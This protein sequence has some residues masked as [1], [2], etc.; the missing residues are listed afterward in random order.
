MAVGTSQLLTM[1]HLPLPVIRSFLPRRLFF[2]NN[3][4]FSPFWAAVPAAIIPA[5][6][7]PTIMTSN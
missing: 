1:L 6:P 5:A 4:V 7:P 2:S 3:N